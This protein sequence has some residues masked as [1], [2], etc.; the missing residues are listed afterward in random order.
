MVP[1]MAGWTTL[2]K[3]GLAILTL[4]LVRSVNGAVPPDK[5]SSTE[6]ATNKVTVPFEFVSGRILV[7]AR[8]NGSRPGSVLGGLSY[9]WA[10]PGRTGREFTYAT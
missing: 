1:G 4:L 7:S 10:E 8:I 9:P 5:P 2:P 3:I 6:S